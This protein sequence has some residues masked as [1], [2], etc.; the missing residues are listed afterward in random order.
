LTCTNT[1]QVTEEHELV[2]FH[3]FAETFRPPNLYSDKF[4]AGDVRSYKTV[5]DENG[6][7]VAAGEA[8]AALSP[9]ETVRMRDPEK[10]ERER[11]R[12]RERG[13]EGE[14]RSETQWETR[15]DTAREAVR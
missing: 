7:N 15:W 12:E 3:Q 6:L 8:P 5:V 1:C 10:S 14:R 9:R 11:E 2:P 4:D 13:R